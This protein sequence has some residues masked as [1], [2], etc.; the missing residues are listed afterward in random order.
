MPGGL[1][2][3]NN[4][5]WYYL[6][7]TLYF[8][9]KFKPHFLVLLNHV[10]AYRP[11]VNEAFQLN[12]PVIGSINF[13]TNFLD[14]KVAYNIYIPLNNVSRTDF[15]LFFIEIFKYTLRL[16]N[17]LSYI[18]NT[19]LLVRNGYKNLLR[20]LRRTLNI[21]DVFKQRRKLKIISII[22][23]KR[24]KEVRKKIKEKNKIM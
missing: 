7:N 10:P 22:N 21:A 18:S 20:Y 11:I 16:F 8:F 17:S 2:N 15:R 23:K 19:G 24:K 9:P 3:F 13:N 14:K 12:I 6:K 4:M 1:T 5:R